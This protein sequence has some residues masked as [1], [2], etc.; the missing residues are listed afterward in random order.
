MRIRDNE[1][2]DEGG[3]DITPLLD[4]MFILIIFFLVTMTF[5][6]EEHDITVNLPET[7]S[8]LS[9]PVTALV[10]N[11]REDGSYYIG[12][13]PASLTA[14][15]AELTELVRANP[16]QKVL[17]RADQNALHGMVA[18]A[19][20]QCKASGITDANIGYVTPG[21]N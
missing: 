6:Q 2:S 1:T 12:P 10:I 9:A 16:Q 14:I 3:I 19:I 18:A 7:E 13:R 4:L 17:V 20:A 11:I 5:S 8:T 15:R 21:E